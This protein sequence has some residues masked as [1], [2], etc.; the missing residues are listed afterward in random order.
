[1]PGGGSHQGRAGQQVPPGRQPWGAPA[2]GPGGAAHPRA[3]APPS[4]DGRPPSGGAPDGGRLALLVGVVVGLVVGAVGFLAL[5]PTDEATADE[6]TADGGGSGV[7]VTTSAGAGGTEGEAAAEG[8]AATPEEQMVYDLAEA[9]NNQD[10]AAIV[11]LTDAAFWDE[12]FGVTDEAQVAGACESALGSG[13]FPPV[14]VYQ[15]WILTTR[16]DFTDVAALNRGWEGNVVTLRQDDGAVRVSGFDYESDLV[17]SDAAQSEAEGEGSDSGGG[18]LDQ[19]SGR[20]VTDPTDPPA[21]NATY[22]EI[23]RNCHGGSMVA[24][25]DLYWVSPRGSDYE[26]YGITCG[27]RRLGVF[28]GGHC[29]RDFNRQL[30]D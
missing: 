14:R 22:D 5:A 2:P 1:M 28:A 23:A 8:Q 21:G 4:P 12:V 3:T 11:G 20:P 10:C 7:T 15:T 18:A 27:G 6:T 19:P 13:Q 26:L 30:D 9:F 17:E 25:D 29:E 16:G 24:C